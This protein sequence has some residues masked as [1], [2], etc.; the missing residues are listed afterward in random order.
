MRPLTREVGRGFLKR[1]STVALVLAFVIPVHQRITLAATR[2]VGIGG[3]SA[4]TFLPW[5]PEQGSQSSDPTD[6]NA[7][8][9]REHS[10]RGLAFASNGNF[11]DAAAELR[12]AVALAPRN[13]Q[14]LY[15]LGAVLAQQG[16][17]QEARNHFQQA[18]KL[19]PTNLVIRRNLAAVEW[20]MGDLADAD[21]NLE[22]ILQ[23][24][25]NDADASFLLGMVLENRGTYAKAAKLLA[26]AHGQLNA[27]P[28]AVAALLHCYYETSH[29]V[30]AHALEDTL[31]KDPSQTQPIFMSAGV[32]ER[33]GDYPSAEKMLMALHD[34][35]PSLSEVNYQIAILRYRTGACSEAEP[36]LQQLISED[37]EARY[38][39]LLAWC[40]AKEDK[41][42]EAVKAFDR[43]IDLAPG[44]VSNYVDL[45]T[46]LM[47]ADLLAPALE[48]ST[49][50]IEV[51]P[52][53]YDA[54]RVRGQIQMS[55]HDF[56]AAKESYARAAEL[57]KSAPEALL[58]LAGA[59]AAA[60]EFQKA[61]VLLQASIKKYPREAQ[62]YY[63][64]ALILIYHS[65]LGQRQSQSQAI[66]LLEKTLALDH[67]I[68]GAHYELGNIY[69]QQDQAAKAVGELQEAEKLN[70]SDENTH[71]SLWVGLRK[72]G[73][74]QEAE[75]ELQSFRKL[76]GKSPDNDKS[77]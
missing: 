51:A 35:Y 15:T 66:A 44:E 43:A 45:A 65:H 63:Q 46:V 3:R 18:L 19:D 54:Y 71:Y 55:Q 76:K 1:S 10:E 6:S 56:N 26:A 67:S 58:D 47:R 49:K 25:P 7:Q 20:Q 70:P 40:L 27:H 5:Q 21:R 16:K 39:N 37:G 64:W 73:R 4:A 9:A 17:L 12:L 60:G 77:R 32:A 2:L 13:A 22:L 28:E 11:G 8:Q 29:I 62:F 74:Q 24:R 59:Q 72:L 41:I 30:E 34:L 23:Q 33:A 53:S 36:I 38:F 69:L 57:S 52:G 48:A 75:E 61:A 42:N 31:L 68:A 50:A 14:Y